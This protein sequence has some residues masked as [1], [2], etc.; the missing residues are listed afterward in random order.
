[1]EAHAHLG[2][3]DPI[4]VFLPGTDY[5]IIRSTTSS[6]SSTL[7]KAG[8]GAGAGPGVAGARVS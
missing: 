8:P 7:A 6:L 5:M 4:N 3:Q 1:M 2:K